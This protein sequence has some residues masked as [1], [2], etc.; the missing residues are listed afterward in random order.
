MLFSVRKLEEHLETQMR[1]DGNTVLNGSA[2]L[3]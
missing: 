1:A 2:S 3:V